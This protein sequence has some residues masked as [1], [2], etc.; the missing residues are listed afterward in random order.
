[1]PFR[2]QV[3]VPDELLAMLDDHVR[4]IELAMPGT[5]PTRSSVLRSWL[6]DASSQMEK[7]L[8][9]IEAAQGRERRVASPPLAV[10]PVRRGGIRTP[11][12][13]EMVKPKKRPPR[14]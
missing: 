1:M 9:A 3:V 4:R 11:N 6:F 10:T 8:S 13:M 12:P 5:Q 14:R 7:S 2:V